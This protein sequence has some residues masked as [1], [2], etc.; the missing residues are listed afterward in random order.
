MGSEARSA[1]AA[2]RGRGIGAL[3]FVD[4]LHHRVVA[5]QR[6]IIAQR[7]RKPANGRAD[8]ANR[9]FVRGLGRFEHG[10]V[11]FDQRDRAAA[12]VASRDRS[13]LDPRL[14]DL[15]AS[16]HFEPKVD[17]SEMAAPKTRH[18]SRLAVDG[19]AF[20]VDTRHTNKSSPGSS[21]C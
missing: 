6:E 11:R 17:D 20:C 19:A 16:V 8:V 9:G 10:R 18:E 14:D 15:P 12:C 1:R 4:E 2:A 21:R 3:S 7:S 5:D 13:D